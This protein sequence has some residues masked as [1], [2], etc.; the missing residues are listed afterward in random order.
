M[1]IEL[2]EIFKYFIYILVGFGFN[3]LLLIL[4]LLFFK[5]T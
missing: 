1:Y 5:F 2:F 4:Q 3:N